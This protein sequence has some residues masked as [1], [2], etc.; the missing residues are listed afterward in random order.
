MFINFLTCQSDHS[1]I[2]LQG[3]TNAVTIDDLCDIMTNQSIGDELDR[4]A[5]V[6]DMFLKMYDSDSLDVNYD[7]YVE[8]MKSTSWTSPA[9]EGGKHIS[10]ISIIY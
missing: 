3:A 7:A 2:F 8:F 5:A 6:N 9:A 4:Y 1:I 10:S